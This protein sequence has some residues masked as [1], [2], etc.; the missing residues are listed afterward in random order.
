AQ[1]ASR[2]LDAA[3]ELDIGLAAL[4]A[5]HRGR[6]RVSASLTVAEHLLPGWLVSY[7]AAARARDEQ[8][9]EITLIAANSGVVTEHVRAGT[10]D[11]G[12]IESPGVPGGLRSRVVARDEL[13]LVVRPDY[14]FARRRR[15]VDPALLAQ[16]PLVSREIGSGT[17]EA[18]TAALRTAL[19]PG[20]Q[21]ADPILALST[22]SAIRGAVHAGAGPAVLSR[23]AVQDDLATRRLVSVPVA[24]L[25]L[26]R[27]LR[28]VWL[29][30]STPP[31]GAARDLIAHIAARR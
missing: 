28:A 10:A 29:G 8:P 1:W 5:E 27:A 2:V 13:L 4:R 20:L 16:T 11:L 12:F 17:R 18:L 7:H 24:G 23:L 6:L 25:D 30:A 15:P 26:H 14:P 9:A 31:A 3:H 19:G 22:T 21:Q